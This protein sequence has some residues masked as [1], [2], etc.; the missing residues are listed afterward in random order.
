MKGTQHSYSPAFSQILSVSRVNYRYPCRQ[1]L[2]SCLVL[3]CLLATYV[4]PSAC[5]YIEFYHAILPVLFPQL[6]LTKRTM[7]CRFLHRCA[8]WPAW[9]VAINFLVTC[10]LTALTE[11]APL[12]PT[13][14]VTIP[15]PPTE[16]QDAFN[17][18]L[19]TIAT[20]PPSTGRVISFFK[21]STITVDLL[22]IFIEPCMHTTKSVATL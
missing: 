17:H 19:S 11:G 9:L 18:T 10:T 13:T 3:Y 20:P 15:A 22:C 7:D 21:V 6:Q 8:D 16:H 5:R 12:L 14:T 2:G 4:F 1:K